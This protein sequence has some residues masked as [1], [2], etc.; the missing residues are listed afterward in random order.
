MA[1]VLPRQAVLPGFLSL[2][3]VKARV[4]EC[5]DQK[6]VNLL[7]GICAAVLFVAMT[8]YRIDRAGMY[9]DELFQATGA[10]AYTG[11]TATMFAPATVL[12]LPIMTMPYSGAIKT[13]V[14]GAYLRAFNA[15]FGITSWRVLGIAFGAVGILLFC[16]LS[17]ASLRSVSLAAFLALLLTDTNLLLQ[18]KHDWGPA[19]LAFFLR[20]VFIGAWL[21]QTNSDARLSSSWLLGLIVGTAVYEK[22]SSAVLL[23]V[24]ALVIA[25]DVRRRSMRHAGAAITGVGLATL[26][27]TAINIRSFVGEGA[28]FSL[29][30]ETDNS[31]A[32]GIAEYVAQFLALGNGGIVRQFI[33][34]MPR[35]IATEWVEGM[36]MAGLVLVV[37]TVGAKRWGDSSTA[38][39]GTVCLL[40]FLAIAVGL[41]WLPA[42]TAENHWIIAS[43]FQYLA[44]AFT[45]PLLWTNDAAWAR[46]RKTVRTLFVVAL[47]ALLIGRIPALASVAQATSEDRYSIRWHPSLSRMAAFAAAQ[48]EG[49]VVIA[50]NWGVAAQIYCMAD[51]RENFVYELFWNYQGPEQLAAILNQPG[52][53]QVIIARRHGTFM[54]RQAERILSDMSALPGWAEVTADPG[55]HNLPAVEVRVFRRAPVSHQTAPRRLQ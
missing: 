6:R 33:F 20:M 21:R 42:A 29:S 40:A 39:R 55:V 51:G 43:P 47:F 1:L 38:R 34:D 49:T 37:A 7:L 26:P 23:P 54:K 5:P 4:T 15:Q 44:I 41:R 8:I 50:A 28:F 3:L 27:V 16:W 10:F 9:Y 13:A 36:A 46:P 52:R 2:W 45:L 18:V 35:W 12:G 31:D 14:Y 11:R 24:L 22:L 25:T 19:A 32:P 17:A 30:S 48:P 53:S